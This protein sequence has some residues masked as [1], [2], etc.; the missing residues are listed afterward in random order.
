MPDDL[1]LVG[2]VA[3]PHGIK[4]QV[5]VN[6]ETDFAEQ[7]F[8]TG[9]SL[10]V[11]PEGAPTVRRIRDVRFHQGRPVVGFEG[12]DTMNDAEALAGAALWVEAGGRDPLPEHTFYRHDL[13]GCDV[14]DRGGRRVG[15]VTAV[16]GAMERSYL[17]VQGSRGEVMIPLRVE[18]V[19]VDVPAKRI[20]VDP[21]EGL[22][23][24][25]ER[26]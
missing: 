8:R 9:R 18:M 22:L 1:I 4:G 6:P 3:R 16:E 23:E 25:N 2:R 13:V 26:P 5:V 20:T 24:V 10:L 17:I 21:P 15:T 12:V 19:T 7:R 14:V 11:G